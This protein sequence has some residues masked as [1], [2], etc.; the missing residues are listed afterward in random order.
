MRVLA[1]SLVASCFGLAPCAVAASETPEIRTL[2]TI[3]GKE[4]MADNFS[5]A[6]LDGRW[7]TAKGKW[8]IKDGVLHGT[9]VAADMHAASIRTD[10]A[11]T[12]AIYQFDFRF[13]QGK[14]IHLSI[15][16]AKGH[17][18]RVTISPNGFVL[19][20]DGS[21]QDAADKPVVLDSCRFAFEHGKTYTMVVEVLGSEVLARLDDK[22]YGLGG[23]QKLKSAKT[24]FGFPISGE[25]SIDNLKVWE[26][27]PNSDWPKIREKLTAE[28]PPKLPTPPARPANKKAARPQN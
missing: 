25:G 26:A 15:N 27:K 12:D 7:K 6:T 20:K 22:Q 18:C 2:M 10:L 8:A 19:K 1:L 3:K 11:H 13:D 9:E 4:L 21:K 16:G 24:N 17:I 23:D 28:H 5:S 14:V